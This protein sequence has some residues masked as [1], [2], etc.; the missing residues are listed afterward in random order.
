MK[1]RISARPSYEVAGEG[2]LQSLAYVDPDFYNMNKE[3]ASMK[4]QYKGWETHEVN[5]N[6]DPR[7]EEV[8]A[9]GIQ[10]KALV[11]NVPDIYMNEEI[12]N[13]IDSSKNLEALRGNY[14]SNNQPIRR[15][16]ANDSFNTNGCNGYYPVIY[17]NG[18]DFRELIGKCLD[19][20][21][22]YNGNIGCW[23]TARVTNMARAFR[24]Q[25]DFNEDISFW[26]TAQ[27]TYMNF[28]FEGTKFNQDISYWDTESVTMMNGMFASSFFNQPI[29]V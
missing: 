8:K 28:M 27:V 22:P 12:A 6:R 10:V 7:Y 23:D 1:R 11:N 29:G 14:A 16:L 3:M 19:G 15:K 5:H 13:M 9:G 20:S 21:C 4:D 24:G 26:T 2:D 18:Y 17:K 25:S